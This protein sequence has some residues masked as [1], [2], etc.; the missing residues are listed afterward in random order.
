M[1]N[2]TLDLAMAAFLFFLGIGI[3][4]GATELGV[5]SPIGPTAG[6]FP[7][8]GGLL[9]SILSIFNFVRALRGIEVVK[10]AIRGRDALSIAGVVV[11]IAVYLLLVDSLG[12]FLTLPFFLVLL[13][14]CVEWRTDPKW[15]LSLFAGS[16]VFSIGCYFV[17][18]VFLRMLIPPGPFGF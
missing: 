6:T 1:S 14:L 13:S 15:L 8:A 17:F 2:R 12:M 10:G 16:V 7:M 4:L 3:I 9:L 5:W 18:K 11:V